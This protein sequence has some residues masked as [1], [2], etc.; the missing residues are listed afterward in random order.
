MFVISTHVSNDV[1]P[2]L[3][4]AATICALEF[5]RSLGWIANAKLPHVLSG[6]RH[7][8]ATVMNPALEHAFLNSSICASVSDIFTGFL[9]LHFIVLPFPPPIDGS[10][11]VALQ[12]VPSPCFAQNYVRV[13]HLPPASAWNFAFPFLLSSFRDNLNI[14]ASMCLVNSSWTFL[15]SFVA[16]SA[17]SA[18]MLNSLSSTFNLILTF[19]YT[20]KTALIAS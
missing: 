15:A 16:S 2:F 7:V 8:I 14:S 5:W 20:S 18:C 17:Y 6:T 12:V 1:V 3:H 4:A 13:L 19:G 11:V 10:H 9:C